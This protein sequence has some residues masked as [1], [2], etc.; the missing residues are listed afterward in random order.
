MKSLTEFLKENR[1]DKP[2]RKDFQKWN[3]ETEEY[4]NKINEEYDNNYY[5]NAPINLRYENALRYPLG[6]LDSKTLSGFVGDREISEELYEEFFR[7][8]KNVRRKDS[9]NFFNS[10]I[11]ERLKTF[12]VE[13]IIYAIEKRFYEHSSKFHFE[14]V[15]KENK[16]D[17]PAA[18]IFDIKD[19]ET[20][21]EDNFDRLVELCEDYGYYVTKYGAFYS[22]IYIVF[23]PLNTENL[24]KEIKSDYDNKIYH[25][26]FKDNVDSIKK[27]GIYI[28]SIKGDDIEKPDYFSILD[29]K[30]TE[31]K[32]PKTIREKI[33]KSIQYRYFT[34]RSFFFATKDDIQKASKKVLSMLNK[35]Y[36]MNDCKIVEIDL[37]NHNFPLYKDTMMISD[38]DILFCYST[39]DVPKQLISKI[40]DFSY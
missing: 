12:P 23:E 40:I 3:N 16:F 9:V 1:I 22:T 2:N 37:K 31:G 19:Y 21:I 26:T 34:N 35:G 32:L 28:G 25:L 39:I 10:L 18:L 29:K 24:S 27:Y 14:R 13:R 17:E 4:F 6:H 38:K 30:E 8:F 15:D 36:G 11:V 33:N 20:F 7:D 5:S